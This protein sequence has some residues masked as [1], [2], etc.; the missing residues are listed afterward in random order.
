MSAE[1]MPVAL[2]PR[3]KDIRGVRRGLLVAQQYLGSLPN[4]HANWLCLC[5]CGKTHEVDAA[6]FLR[7]SCRS[8]GCYKAETARKQMRTHGKSKNS[9]YYIWQAIIKRTTNPKDPRWENY[10]GRGI[11]CCQ[12]W[13]DSFED[14]Y[15]D[16]G[17]RP[18]PAHSL[19]RLKNNEGY[20]PSNCAWKTAKE[21]AR[22]RRSNHLLTHKGETLTIAEWSERIGISGRTMIARIGLGWSI[23]DIV[24]RPKKVYKQKTH[25]F[26]FE[27]VLPDGTI[28]KCL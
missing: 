3:V 13:L 20:Y 15:A 27:W 5:D 6:T 25:S 11:T 10:G 16:V 9:E 19:D 26:N 24:T 22:N 2:P 4:R 1:N 28:D 7:W 12:R 23:E 18:S 21:Q 14:F 17:P 8:C